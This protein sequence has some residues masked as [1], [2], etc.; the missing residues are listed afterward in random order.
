M[1]SNRH[2]RLL[3]VDP[4]AIPEEK[5]NISKRKRQYFTPRGEYCTNRKPSINEA[6]RNRYFKT[7]QK[8]KT[9]K[10]ESD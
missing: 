5:V 4:Y 6:R 3:L 2:A 9:I 8:L 7:A 10:W 1:K